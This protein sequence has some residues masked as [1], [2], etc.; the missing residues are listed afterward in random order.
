MSYANE[1]NKIAHSLSFVDAH[2]QDTWVK[3]GMAVKSQL[4]EGGFELWRD[5]SATAAN[6]NEK[7]A[8]KRWKSFKPTGGVTIASLYAEA[9]KQGWKCAEACKQRSRAEELAI[10]AARAEAEKESAQ[11]EK[12]RHTLAAG[13]ARKQWGGAT[14]ALANH[15]YC[16]RKGIPPIRARQDKNGNLLIPLFDQSGNLASV[17]TIPPYGK[18]KW[19]TT[20]GKVSGCSLTLKG[21]DDGRVLLCEGWATGCSLHKTLG[22]TV[23]V[24]FS[25]Y[26]LA[27]VA[28]KLDNELPYGSSI[29]VCGDVDNSGAGQA[30]VEAAARQINLHIHNSFTY[31]PTFTAEENEAW[32]ARNNGDLPSDFN[33][34]VAIGKTPNDSDFLAIRK[35][36]L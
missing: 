13:E 34:Y 36:V 12:E 26:N 28:R 23:I 7:R 9:K 15:P 35:G 1:Y 11:Q 27:K 14:P 10:K 16:K 4:G 25:A 3:M 2:D 20:G 17:Q 5:W 19:F 22:S 33:D 29:V 6:Y 30:A 21:R 18:S 8:I 31:F 24:A 32:A